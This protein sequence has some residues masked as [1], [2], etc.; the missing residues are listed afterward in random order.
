MSDLPEPR[1]HTSLPPPVSPRML[2]DGEARRRIR[3]DLDITFVVEAAAGTGKTTELTSRIVALLA[4]G[5]AKLDEIVAV[6]FT[7]KAAGEMKLRLRSGIERA[8]TAEDATPAVQANL[9]RSLAMLEAARIGT[10]HSLCSDLLHEHPLEAEVD[11]LFEVGAEDEAERL[12]DQAFDRWF[13][14]SLRDPPE[15][16]RRM[17]RRRPRGRDRATPREVLRDAAYRL[18]DRRDFDGAW[19]R[20]PWDRTEALGTA[21]LAL[22]AA[23]SVGGPKAAQERDFVG[24]NLQKIARYLEELDRRE[25]VRGRDEDGLEAELRE[26]Q[27]WSEW[28]WR[29]GG[30]QCLVPRNEAIELRDNAKRTVDAFLDAANAD[31]AACL[32]HEL[33]PLLDEYER[34]KKRAGRLDFLDLLLSTRKLLRENVRVREQLSRR[35]S[36]IFVDEFQDTDPLQAEILLLLAADDPSVSRRE[37]VRPRPGKLFV[38]GDP[39]QSIYRFRRADVAFYSDVK[40]QLLQA[41]AELLYLSTSFRSAPSIQ[42]AVNAAFAPLMRGDTHSQARYVP[43]QPFRADP[44]ERPTLIALPVP[45]PYSDFGKITGFKIE[46][47]A[48]EAVAA[49]VEH[50]IDPRSGWTVSERERPDEAVPLAARHVCL[51]FKRFQSAGDDIT[52]PYVRALESRRIPHVLVGGR[53][54]HEREEVIALRSAL[55]AIEWPD[56]ELS[57]FAALRGP[58]FA[59]G[60]DLLIAYR[61]AHRALHPLYALALLD[62]KKRAEKPP[63]PEHEREV[64]EALAVLGRLHAGRNRRPIADTIGQLLERTRAHAGLAIWPTGEQALANVLRVMDLA[65]RFESRGATS[66]RAFVQRV[67]DDAQQGEAAEAP[68]VEEGTDGVRLMTVHRA[69]GLEFPVVVL[70]DPTAPATHAQPTRHVDSKAGKWFEPLAGNM[71]IELYERREEVLARDLEEAHRLAYVAATRARDLLI[72]PVVGDSMVGDDAIRGWVDVLHPVLYPPRSERRRPQRALGCP[73]FPGDDSVLDRGK[74]DIGPEQ[75]VA[76]GLHRPEVGDHTVV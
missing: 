6:T 21:L 73:P 46:E 57:V 52:R 33:R 43:L 41:G 60:D 26:V 75:S 16:V 48:P 11:P 37:D 9:D 29:G 32:F 18:A 2:P 3:E 39:K 58:F 13:A 53:S 44:H 40:R 12:F 30:Y 14:E 67:Q 70:A 63:L 15:G 65:R 1:S 5:R 66:F 20:D 56:D 50:L 24:R 42:R 68:V 47:S 27:R 74:V 45:R 8:R 55:A 38:V 69:K 61:A 4:S 10:I 31:L 54:F 17:L 19:R 51:L 62:P 22:R 76:P 71:P 34:L 59:V 7:E 36:H 64:A 49:I 72:V 35:F 28:R 23:A 25:A